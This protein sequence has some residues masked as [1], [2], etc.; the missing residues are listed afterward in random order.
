[1]Q[2]MGLW[3]LSRTEILWLLR[4]DAMF[5]DHPHD[6]SNLKELLINAGDRYI[7]LKEKDLKKK[8][9]KKKKA[10]PHSELEKYWARSNQLENDRECV[11]K[12]HL[13]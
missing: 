5:E 7:Q 12:M 1:M 4:L 8:L 13:M 10:V 9:D 2:L 11:Q 3:T 6:H